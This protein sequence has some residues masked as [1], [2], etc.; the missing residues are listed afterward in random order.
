MIHR[1]MI[2]ATFLSSSRDFVVA[3]TAA[4]TIALLRIVWRLGER[5]TRLEALEEARRHEPDG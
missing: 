3:V 4:G 5:V 1:S 2:A